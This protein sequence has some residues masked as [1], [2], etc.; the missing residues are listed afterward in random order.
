VDLFAPAADV[1]SASLDPL[2]ACYL[3]GTS[4]AAPHVTGVAALYLQTHPNATPAEIQSMQIS[5]ATVGGVGSANLPPF[6]TNR[7]LYTNY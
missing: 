2:R 1:R 5:T 6:T 7:L 4:M 3:T